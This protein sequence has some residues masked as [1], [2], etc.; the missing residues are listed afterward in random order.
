MKRIVGSVVLMAAVATAGFADLGDGAAARGSFEYNYRGLTRS[1]LPSV[2]ENSLFSFSRDRVYVIPDWPTRMGSEMSVWEM[3]VDTLW[4]WWGFDQE[5]ES[6]FGVQAIPPDLTFDE[7]AA[8]IRLRFPRGTGGAILVEAMI[9]L[10]D[11]LYGHICDDLQFGECVNRASWYYHEHPPHE[12][13][14]SEK[15]SDDAHEHRHAHDAEQ[16]SHRHQH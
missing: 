11:E 13:E 16:H 1:E 5:I 8:R 10:A 14:D 15:G 7:W 3:D 9:R 4:A 2:D 6:L 12:H